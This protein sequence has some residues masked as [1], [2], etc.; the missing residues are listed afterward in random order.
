MNARSVAHISHA[1]SHPG[2]GGEPI[3]PGATCLLVIG[4]EVLGQVE[5]GDKP[6]I[7]FVDAH[8]ESDGRDDDDAFFLEEAVLVALAHRG[9]EPGVIGERAAALGTEPVCDLLDLAPREAIHD[10]GV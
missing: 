3:S 10:A 1:I 2:V 4:F 9:V 8:A 5:M 6:H 7:G